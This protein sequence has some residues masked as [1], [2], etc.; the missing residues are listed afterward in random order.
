MPDHL[1]VEYGPEEVRA[2]I[3]ATE[4]FTYT[5]GWSLWSADNEYSYDALRP[6]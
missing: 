1:I 3:N 6:E 4:A 2:Q 5:A